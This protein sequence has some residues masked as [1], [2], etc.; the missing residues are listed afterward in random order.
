MFHHTVSSRIARVICLV[1][2][3]TS[4]VSC[5]WSESTP[6]AVAELDRGRVFV[7]AVP[8]DNPRVYYPFDRSATLVRL[9]GEPTFKE[10]VKDGRIGIER[11][12]YAT[13]SFSPKDGSPP[14][15]CGSN[16]MQ[17]TSCSISTF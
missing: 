10:G 4:I 16:S 6:V 9:N 14:R 15:C 5:G 7:N 2:G 12:V 8:S 1:I 17:P 11:W 13:R 3:L